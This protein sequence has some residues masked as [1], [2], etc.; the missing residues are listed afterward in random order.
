MGEGR[1]LKKDHWHNN[2][3]MLKGYVGG[4]PMHFYPSQEKQDVTVSFYSINPVL[5]I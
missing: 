3:A 1:Q 2:S 5:K 4:R